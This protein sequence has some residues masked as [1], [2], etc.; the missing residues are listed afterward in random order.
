M[1]LKYIIFSLSILLISTHLDAE[2]KSGMPQLD[3][4]SFFSQVFW[5]IIVFSILFIFINFLFLPKIKNV[6]SRRA[7]IIKEN[8]INAEKNNKK[9]EELNVKIRDDI[10]NAKLRAEKQLKEAHDKSMLIF[11]QQL[12]KQIQKF[13]HEESELLKE[14]EIKKK[15]VLYNIDKYAISLSDKIFKDILNKDQKMSKKEFEECKGILN[16]DKFI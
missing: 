9:I 7:N 5:L 14:I 12:K 3:P 8:L 13:E 16:V 15:E 1:V 4:A 10:S 2:N 11:N 6:G